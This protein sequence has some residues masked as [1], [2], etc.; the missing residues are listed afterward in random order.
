MAEKICGVGGDAEI[1]DEDEIY[2]AFIELA[3]C[4][5]HVE[6]SSAVAYAAYKKQKN[7]GEVGENEVSVIVLTGFGLK[8]MLK[9]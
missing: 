6:P 8:S 7:A 5:F 3:R 9:P 1:V 2:S 4:G